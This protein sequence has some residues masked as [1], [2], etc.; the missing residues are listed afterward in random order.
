MNHITNFNLL[1]LEKQYEA[2]AYKRFI[3]LVSFTIIIG[4]WLL[5]SSCIILT[6]QTILTREYTILMD[7]SRRLMTYNNYISKSELGRTI[8]RLEAETKSAQSSRGNDYRWSVLLPEITSGIPDDIILTGIETDN[9]M[10]QCVLRGD[11]AHRDALLQWK[12]SL[13]KN[14]KIESINLPLS[15]LLV[16]DDFDFTLTLTLKES[17]P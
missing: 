7:A 10:R 15:N 3:Q 16:K 2:A 11:T 8:H 13:Q 6:T 4:S 1:P 17:Q 14:E 5:V 9:S 12:D